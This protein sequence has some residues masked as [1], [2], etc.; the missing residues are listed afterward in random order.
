VSATLCLFPAHGNRV[1]GNVFSGNGSFGNVTN[2]D[3]GTVGLLAAATPRNCF[4]ANHATHG[5]VTSAP[6]NIQR[7]SVDG[8]PCSKPGTTANAALLG[9]LIC[10]TGATQLGIPCPSG[11]HYPQQTRIVMAPIPRLP[12]MPNPCFG[13]PRNGFCAQ[14]H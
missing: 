12:S 5:P 14:H 11:S 9:Q 3:L 8:V 6:A 4:F 13:V 2:G 1:Y 10:A 7:P